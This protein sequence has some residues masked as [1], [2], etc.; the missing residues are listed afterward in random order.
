MTVT[1]TDTSV[2]PYKSATAVVKAAGVDAGTTPRRE[3]QVSLPGINR[4][5]QAVREATER[6]N[7]LLLNDLSFNLGVFDERLDLEVG[8][9][10]AVT[11]PIGL[12]AKLM[13]VL[14]LSGEYGRYNL[15][16]VEYDPA[17]YDASVA[18]APTY[19]DTDLPNPASPP[20]VAGVTM[21]EEVFQ[22]E[23]GNWSSRWRITWSAAAYSFLAHYR[24]ELWEG[25]TLIHAASPATAEW[26][27][28]A[29]QEGVTYTA[30]VAAVSSIGATGTWATQSATAAGKT[31]IPSDVPSV[32]AFEAG[33]RVYVSWA[34]AV[35]IDIWRY[36]V[37]YGLPGFAASRTAL[38]HDWIVEPPSTARIEA[39]AFG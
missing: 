36:E 5:S 2:L 12:S 19:T 14:G 22:L 34:P 17:V 18:T 13:R 4:Y 39:D 29:V 28:P 38:R 25:A 21:T 32:S 31:L 16:L 33:G 37:R 24:A 8:D 3:S 11:H 9:I 15:A 20:A 30:K 7:K 27:T 26:P 35:D 1:Y 6:L 23:N 10:V